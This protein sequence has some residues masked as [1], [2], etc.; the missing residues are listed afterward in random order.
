MNRFVHFMG[1]LAL[2]LLGGQAALA[3]TPQEADRLG[4]DLTA[5]G[6]EK[7]GNAD[8]TIPAWQGGDTPLPGW[9]WGKYRGDYW[10][11]KDDKPLFSI[12]ASNVDKY[13]ARLT[14]AQITA[15]K[16]VKGYRMDIYPTHRT[17]AITPSYAERSKENAT[18]AKIAPD[19]WKLEHARA[20]GVPFPIPKSGIEAMYNIKMR[21]AGTGAYYDDGTSVISPRAGSS[22]FTWYQWHLEQFWPSKNPDKASV[23]SDNGVDFFVYYAYSKPAALAGQGFVGTIGMNTDPEEYYYFPGQRRV[24][25]LPSYVFDTPLIGFENQYLVDEETGIWMTLDRYD[26]KLLGKKEMYVGADAFGMWN[27]KADPK[28][29]FD[30]TYINPAYRHYELRRVWVIDAHLKPGYRHLAP[31]RT[32]YADED[33][34]NM[35]ELTDYDKDEKVWKDVAMFEIPTWEVGGLCTALST[36]MWDLQ[37]GRYVVDWM[38]IGG[39]KD[40]RWVKEG[41]PDAKADWMKPGHYTPE[42]LRS[43]SER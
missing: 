21:P 10:K 9:E 5:F 29:V 11:Y 17:C 26:Y 8:G 15:L 24:R 35:V 32:Y 13:A 37:A 31:H 16:T 23:E 22:D 27:Y 43:L 3:V 4:K 14:D 36:E 39:G 34:W 1:Y 19:G 18:E 6:A 12:D 42:T 33:S 38:S 28:V 41:D 7:A 40:I 20:G 2:A 30:K 25:R